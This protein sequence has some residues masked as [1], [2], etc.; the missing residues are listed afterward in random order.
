MSHALRRLCSM[1]VYVPL[2][3]GVADESAALLCPVIAQR[4]CAEVRK[5]LLIVEQKLKRKSGN[6][7]GTASATTS[8]TA[9]P[10]TISSAADGAA[11]YH[12]P[13]LRALVD[14]KLERH[15]REVLAEKQALIANA[16]CIGGK[17][18]SCSERGKRATN[19]DA[20]VIQPFLL[21][22]T[23]NVKVGRCSEWMF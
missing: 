21:A 8:A 15:V 11:I 17:S 1:A 2:L 19:E 12:T 4:V 7:S 9:L 16:R 10:G 13:A 14:R 20:F 6:A 22:T 5:A 18:G 23:G 3:T